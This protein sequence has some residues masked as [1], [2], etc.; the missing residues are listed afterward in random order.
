MAFDPN[1]DEV[2]ASD[3]YPNENAGDLNVSIVRYNGGAPKLQI[4][5]R[6]K[7]TN[8]GP[9]YVKAGR[10]NRDEAEWLRELLDEWIPEY[11]DA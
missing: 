1:L 2:V 10:L 3:T 11:M 9:K 5:S 8:D 6:L 4:G 7:H